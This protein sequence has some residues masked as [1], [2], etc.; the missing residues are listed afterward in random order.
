MTVFKD[1]IEGGDHS[2]YTELLNALMNDIGMTKKSADTLLNPIKRPAAKKEQ[3]PIITKKPI[4]KIVDLNV[5]ANTEV[6]VSRAVSGEEHVNG[7]D[8]SYSSLTV[9]IPMPGFSKNEIVVES[10]R[11]NTISIKTNK[12]V[13]D[14][15]ANQDI[16][17][18]VARGDV[19]VFD[20]PIFN[21][22]IHKPEVFIEFAE[23]YNVSRSALNIDKGM[24][25]IWVPVRKDYGHTQFKID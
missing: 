18:I 14:P 25:I 15:Y 24:L 16:E 6:Y 12:K 1:F 9:M 13:S 3:K 17:P 5:N 11:P 22:P 7:K 19:D 8:D 23:K 4:T 21:G 10:D 20:C 2:A